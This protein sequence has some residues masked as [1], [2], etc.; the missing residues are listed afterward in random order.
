MSLVDI[1]AEVIESVNKTPMTILDFLDLAEAAKQSKVIVY[2][3]LY[4]SN[5]LNPLFMPEYKVM[6]EFWGTYYFDITFSYQTMYIEQFTMFTPAERCMIERNGISNEEY[7][8]EVLIALE[9]IMG[10]LPPE[11]WETYDNAAKNFLHIQA[12]TGPTGTI[13]KLKPVYKYVHSY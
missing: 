2:F 7:I 4:Q 1:R 6:V 5:N 8:F 9:S 3:T 13:F 10:T 11:M 12:M